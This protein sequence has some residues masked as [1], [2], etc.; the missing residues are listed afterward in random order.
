MSFIKNENSSDDEITGNYQLNYVTQSNN[1]VENCNDQVSV[2]DIE[3]TEDPV[4]IK[5]MPKINNILEKRKA[6]HGIILNL[7]KKENSRRK[8]NKNKDIKASRQSFAIRK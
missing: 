8:F 6:I 4:K 3:E 5:E 2:N 1:D 7:N